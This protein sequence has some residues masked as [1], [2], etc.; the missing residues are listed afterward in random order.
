MNYTCNPWNILLLQP[1]NLCP[2][3]SHCLEIPS[4]TV[5]L[6]FT[7]YPHLLSP[8]IIQ[9][10]ITLLISETT[11]T[12]PITP[13]ASVYF[14]PHQKPQTLIL[15]WVVFNL[16]CLHFL[17]LV[18]IQFPK[19]CWCTLCNLWFVLIKTSCIFHLS[20]K[21]FLYLCALTKTWLYTYHA[22]FYVAFSVVA[23]FP[24]MALVSL[25]LKLK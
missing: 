16:V 17:S 11:K 5:C 18:L 3:C 4:P 2:G 1:L 6:L 21:H 8:S 25:S 15:R 23:N 20:I 24:P 7:G 22:I 9:N 14:I 12:I 19:L 10:F 13:L